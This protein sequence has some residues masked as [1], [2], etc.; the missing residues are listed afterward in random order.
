MLPFDPPKRVILPPPISVNN[1]FANVPG[2]GRVTTKEYSSW[3]REAAATLAASGP[4]RQFLVPVEIT[5]FIGEKGIGQMDAG[6]VEK[7]ATD[8]IVAAGILRD[9]SRKWLRAV[10]LLWVPGMRS[11]VAVIT[12]SDGEVDRHDV[13]RTIPRGLWGYLL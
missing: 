9:D 12:Q 2:R 11:I 7:A 3:K 8:A 1:L 4:H 13:M 10:S 6:N 5:Y